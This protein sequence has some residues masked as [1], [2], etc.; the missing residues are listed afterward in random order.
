MCVARL[1]IAIVAFPVLQM[2][3][4]KYLALRAPVCTEYNATTGAAINANFIT[5]LQSPAGLVVAPVPEPSPWSMIAM[6]G[7]ALLRN[8]APEKTPHRIDILS[9]IHQAHIDLP[10]AQ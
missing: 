7:V 3:L 4:V 8:H 9:E 2:K 10:S 5:G 6:G 1:R